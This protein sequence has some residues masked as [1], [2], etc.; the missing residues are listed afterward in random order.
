MKDLVERINTLAAKK[1]AGTITE[2]ELKEQKELRQQYLKLFRGNFDQLLTSS[3]IIDPE[4][5]DVTP[6]KLKAKQAQIKLKSKLNILSVD[7]DN[8]KA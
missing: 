6:K 4:G 5:N 3:T 7:D 2:I 1:K 8:N